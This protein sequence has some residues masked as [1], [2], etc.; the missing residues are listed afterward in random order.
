MQL[1]RQN[2]LTLHQILGAFPPGNDSISLM[3]GTLTVHHCPTR[4]IK[5]K[6]YNYSIDTKNIQNKYES[7]NVKE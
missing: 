7:P 3:A 4:P 5:V 6:R 2:T 1:V